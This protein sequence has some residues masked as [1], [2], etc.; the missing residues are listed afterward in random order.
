[1]DQLRNVVKFEGD[2]GETFE[3]VILK[4]FEDNNKKYAIL[5][6]SEECECD[7]DCGCDDCKCSDDCDCAEGEECDKDCECGESCDCGDDCDDDCDCEKSI[8]IVEVTKD[9]D[10][11]EEFKEIESEEE[12]EKLIEKA[13][14]LLF[15]EK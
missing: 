4:E 14:K 8:F 9:K 15:E 10:G 6:D 3:M 1:M 5:M 7:E 11:V 12:Y 2:N 13:D